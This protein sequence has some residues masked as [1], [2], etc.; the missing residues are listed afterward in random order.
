MV[1]WMVAPGVD[2]QWNAPQNCASVTEIRSR[3]EGYLSESEDLAF[4]AQAAVVPAGTVYRLDLR[5]EVGGQSSTRTAESSSCEVLA[6][7]CALLVAVHVDALATR[8]ALETRDEAPQVVEPTDPIVPPVRA[9][10]LDSLESTTAS[11]RRGPGPTSQ[12]PRPSDPPTITGYVGPMVGAA[13]GLLP[14]PAPGGGLWGGVDLE[15][16]R[17]EAAAAIWGRANL[18]D[19]F[20]GA[21]ARIAL[22]EGRIRGGPVL[23]V[24]DRVSIAIAGGVRGGAVFAVARRIDSPRPQTTGWGA[25]TLGASVLVRV[26]PRV[27][28]RLGVDAAGGWNRPTYFVQSTD[29]RLQFGR[30][31]LEGYAAA[32][33]HFGGKKSSRIRPKSR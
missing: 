2:V 23:P 18:T 26:H 17:I 20:D 6:D 16:W 29:N 15:R 9:V 33:L 3:I 30:V 10:E 32:E 25:V 22:V 21:S 11:A 14:S 7:T 24:T 13:I 12:P 27:G 8:R 19:A 28:V 1:W 31:G 4:S 5:I